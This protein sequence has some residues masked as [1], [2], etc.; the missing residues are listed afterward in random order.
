ME[1]QAWVILAIGLIA[2]AIAIA[3]AIMNS[4]R[5]TRAEK[6]QQDAATRDIYRK[7]GE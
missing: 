5:K 4:R 1:G 3:Y 7:E 6:L 2:T